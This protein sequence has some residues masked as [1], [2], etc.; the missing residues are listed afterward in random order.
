M[1]V[2]HN[3]VGKTVVVETP[4]SDGAAT[5]FRSEGLGGRTEQLA[6]R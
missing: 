3:E 6:K 5:G 2:L 1:T 4:D